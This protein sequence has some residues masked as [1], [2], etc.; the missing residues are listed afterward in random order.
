MQQNQI[1][2]GFL[3]NIKTVSEEIGTRKKLSGVWDS[4]LLKNALYIDPKS[5]ITE[6]VIQAIVSRKKQ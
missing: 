6:E 5:D 3:A 4:A 1:V 2:A